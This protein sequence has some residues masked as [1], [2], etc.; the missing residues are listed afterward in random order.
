MGVPSFKRLPMHIGVIPDGNRRWALGKGLEKQDGYYHGVKPGFEL[1]KLCVE[2]G[3]K[4][5]TLYGF[6]EDNTRR[7]SIQTQAFRKPKTTIQ[8]VV[9]VPIKYTAAPINPSP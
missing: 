1:Y 3:I 4:E 8:N 7:P 5:L 6:T 9:A 2:L